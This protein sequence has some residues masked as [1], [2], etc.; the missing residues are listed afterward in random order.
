MLQ[1]RARF[2]HGGM[3]LD[4]DP[5]HS[6]TIY[7]FVGNKSCNAILLEASHHMRQAGRTMRGEMSA[8]SVQSVLARRE[9]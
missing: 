9:A 2:V 8:K 4:S 5:A 3:L 7:G 6:V 1:G